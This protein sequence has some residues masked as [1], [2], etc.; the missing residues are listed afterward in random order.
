M[1]TEFIG[2]FLDDG[3]DALVAGAQVVFAEAGAPVALFPAG[4][5]DQVKAFH[6]FAH[7]LKV[8]LFPG[9]EQE[10]HRAPCGFFLLGEEVG[11]VAHDLVGL[12]AIHR[13]WVPTAPHGR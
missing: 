4:C 7:D 8:L 12:R 11:Q 10:D 5:A 13:S 1:A 9:G 6:P 3:E 2:H